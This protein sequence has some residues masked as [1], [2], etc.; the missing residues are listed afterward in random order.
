MIKN[1]DGFEAILEMTLMTVLRRGSTYSTVL[2]KYVVSS[3]V[4]VFIN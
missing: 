4:F 1:Y 2:R 3:K